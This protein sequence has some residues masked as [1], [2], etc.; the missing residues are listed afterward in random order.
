MATPTNTKTWQFDVNNTVF[1]DS[2]T[3]NGAFFSARQ[4][5]FEIKELLINTDSF[6]T[7]WTVKG[8]SD[9][10]TSGASDLWVDANDLIWRADTGGAVF[11][12]IILQQPAIS[13][14]FQLLIGCEEDS[15][16]F[17]G[18]Q[19][20]V[21]VS[22]VG[23]TG[24]TTTTRPTATDEQRLRNYNEYWGSGQVNTAYTSQ[25]HV[26]MSSD[27]ECT[28]IVI[29]IRGT[30]TGYWAFEKPA[31]P[32]SAWT[33]PYFACVRGDANVTTD[34]TTY[35]KFYDSALMQSQFAGVDVTMYLS[36]EG[37]ASAA[38]GE[39][40][41]NAGQLTNNWSASSMGLTSTTSTFRGRNGELFDLRWGFK[42]QSNEVRYF[43]AD[44]SKTFIQ[45]GDFIFPWDGSTILRNR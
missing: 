35:A 28:R 15:T 26:W 34:Q 24:G 40:L 20:I 8:S 19:I 42:F 9:S 2:T 25:T 41:I 5:L 12:W 17:D 38:S 18:K 32:V 7:P 45:L 39:I 21:Y 3:A 16:G 22:Q 43:P 10:A 11:S 13:A 30:V 31:N 36:G 27:G 37:F 33:T 29:Y 6:T 4:R 14:A 23:F 44:G 1:A